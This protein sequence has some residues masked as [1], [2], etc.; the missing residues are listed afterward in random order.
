[1]AYTKNAT[2]WGWLGK[3]CHLEVCKDAN[4]SVI[5][6][7]KDGN[8]FSEGNEPSFHKTKCPTVRELLSMTT[9]DWYD[10]DVKTFN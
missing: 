9:D 5:Y 7:K 4:A 1:M 6:C 10:M 8:W 2:T 3:Q